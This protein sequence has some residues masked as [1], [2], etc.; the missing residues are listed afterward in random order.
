MSVAIRCTRLR[1]RRCLAN[2]LPELPAINY[3]RYTISRQLFEKGWLRGQIS[4]PPQIPLSEAFEIFRTNRKDA[5][6]IFCHVSSQPHSPGS[7]I[8]GKFQGSIVNSSV[9]TILSRAIG[10]RIKNQSMR[11][12]ANLLTVFFQLGGTNQEGCSTD[13]CQD[14]R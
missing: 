11:R 8:H 7:S 10:C 2:K 1:W 12:S 5:R 4:P 3:D 14:S 13:A 6:V 9:G